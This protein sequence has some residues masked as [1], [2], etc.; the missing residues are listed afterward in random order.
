MKYKFLE[1]TADVM[2][3]AY[4][5]NVEELFENSGLALEEIMVKISTLEIEESYDITL[6]ADSLENL[7]YDFLSEI[8]FIK[9]TES[10]LF[11]K[12][13]VTIHHGNKKYELIA[14]CKG[15]KINR[16]KHELVDDAKAITMHEFEVKQKGKVWV[17]RV[18]VDI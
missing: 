4:G 7:L 11:K 6:E 9:D 15:E 10:L 16:D 14:E 18:L 17:S 3:E 2:F 13:K 8:I 5:K 1:H 12:F